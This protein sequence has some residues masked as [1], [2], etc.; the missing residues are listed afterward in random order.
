MPDKAQV[1]VQEASNSLMTALL[2]R[3]GSIVITV[4][5][6][7]VLVPTYRYCISL[8]SFYDARADALI[9]SNDSSDNKKIFKVFPARGENI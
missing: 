8:A 4:F 5:I 2:D 7:V 9:L 6:V 3:I 1:I